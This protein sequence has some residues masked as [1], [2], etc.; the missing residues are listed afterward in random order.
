[1][2]W[3]NRCFPP[4][5]AAEL[6]HSWREQHRD[7]AGI[8]KTRDSILGQ[9]GRSGRAFPEGQPPPRHSEPIL[10]QAGREGRAFPEGQLPPRHS[11]LSLG[12]AGRADRS[13]MDRG[14]SKL[15]FYLSLP[16]AFFHSWRA[17]V[18]LLCSC[19]ITFFKSSLKAFLSSPA[20]SRVLPE[21]AAVMP[22]EDPIPEA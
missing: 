5:P 12:T 15:A 6:Q 10:G 18:P 7:H 2:A 19:S 3:G 13:P 4:S 16:S 22:V 8:P 9:Q 14:R 11:Q 17:C 21:C 20:G 1:M